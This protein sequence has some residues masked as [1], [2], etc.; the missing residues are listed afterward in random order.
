M[1]MDVDSIF[2]KKVE[3]ICNYPPDLYKC[4][5]HSTL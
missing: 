4:I 2:P 1:V 5:I 3:S